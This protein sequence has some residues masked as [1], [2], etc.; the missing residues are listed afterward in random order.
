MYNIT[1]YFISMDVKTQFDCTII[2]I[3]ELK[4]FKF[5]QFNIIMQTILI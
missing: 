1:L 2:Y 5:R 4:S 3:L